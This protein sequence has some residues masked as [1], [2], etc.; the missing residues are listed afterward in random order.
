MKNSYINSLINLYKK[1]LSEREYINI[2]I[3]FIQIVHH[4][5]VSRYCCVKYHFIF[6]ISLIQR[7]VLTYRVFGQIWQIKWDA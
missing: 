6:R 4:A 1:I 7:D 2:S 3:L 5:R